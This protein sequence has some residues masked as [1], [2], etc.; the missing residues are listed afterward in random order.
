MTRLP[1]GFAL[2]AF[3]GA[4]ALLPATAQAEN[5]EQE[6]LSSDE[7]PDVPAVSNGTPAQT[8]Q[9]PT[10]ALMQGC[11][12]TLVHPRLVT[13]AAHCGSP[14][15]V[16]LGESQ[17]SVAR[18]IPVDFCLRNPNYNSQENNGVNGE[19]AHFC[20]LSQAVTDVPITPPVYG[21]EVFDIDPDNENVAIVGFGNNS[22]NGGFGTKRFT[23]TSIQAPIGPDSKAAFV[24]TNG[25]DSCS[26]DSGGPAYTVLDDGI[27]R[28][29]G[30]TSGGPEGCG[31]GGGIYVLIHAHMQWI[32]QASGIDITPCF[33]S[34]GSWN[35]TAE[36][37]N[38]SMDPLATGSWSNGCDHARSGYSASCG[39]PYG[40][41]TPNPI[42]EI[43][44]PMDQDLY[45][46][47]TADV[48][49]TF[50]ITHPWPAREVR[51]KINGEVVG[52]RSWPPFEFTVPKFPEG[53]YD[54]IIEVE[55]WAGGVGADAVNIGV[56]EEPNPPPPDPN[57]T[58]DD[59]GS[60]D[61]GEGDGG[62]DGDG[63]GDGGITGGTD[64]VDDG[65]NGMGEG[66]DGCSVTADPDRHGIPLLALTG[67]GLLVAVRRRRLS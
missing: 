54:I 47:P 59:G 2:A 57:P 9:F 8:C 42:V 62:M 25:K 36:C 22:D 52:K 16:R 13:T 1:V 10:T 33:D 44:S 19:D 37:G 32:E 18:T 23:D 56:G 4:V 41:T 55:D 53:K 31:T 17:F 5:P 29:F 45:D 50:E 15:S 38:F 30:I 21:C 3:S 34:D 12:G 27:W 51:M 66:G 43:T 40:E 35:P 58:D 63:S 60:G 39:A 61:G 28:T 64:G 65:V 49:V 24:G 7:T 46:G 26:G 48:P 20:V 6:A 11:T 14:S 67:V